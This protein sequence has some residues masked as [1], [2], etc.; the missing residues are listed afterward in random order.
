MQFHPH[1]KKGK[2]AVFSE[3]N[4]A[5]S[6]ESKYCI[7]DSYEISETH[8][9]G[10]SFALFLP[11]YGSDYGY[12][13][14]VK[15]SIITRLPRTIALLRHPPESLPIY[16]FWFETDQRIFEG[17]HELLRRNRSVGRGRRLTAG[18]M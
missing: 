10:H 8:A 15:G 1:P 11:Y 6:Y 16:R 13:A 2:K 9:A 3:E 12:I 17:F 7:F 4:A 5:F 18:R 14:E